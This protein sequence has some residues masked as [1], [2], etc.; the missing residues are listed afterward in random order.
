[1]VGCSSVKHGF[2]LFQTQM[3]GSINQTA[4]MRNLSLKS[5]CYSVFLDAQDNDQE[6]LVFM[7]DVL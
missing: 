2:I 5:T 1:M 6:Y 3:D 7:M 4:L